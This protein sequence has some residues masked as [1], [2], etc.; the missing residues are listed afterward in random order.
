[1]EGESLIYC[2][3][4][5]TNHVDGATVCV[6]CGAPLHLI[7]DEGRGYIRYGWYEGESGFSMS[8]SPFIGVLFGLAI[9]FVGFSLLVGALY[10]I[11][12]P[13]WPIILIL[14]GVFILVRF[15]QVRGRRRQH[16]PFNHDDV[17]KNELYCLSIFTHKKVILTAVERCRLLREGQRG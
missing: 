6:S 4:C 13:W 1:M 14:A 8:G 10:G 7:S 2:T 11:D 3:K 15:F 9:L 5:G 16:S 17:S 12:I